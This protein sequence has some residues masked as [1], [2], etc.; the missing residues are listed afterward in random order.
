MRFYRSSSGKSKS[1]R[2][3]DVNAYNR[4]KLSGSSKIALGLPSV[5]STDALDIFYTQI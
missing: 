1:K 4:L 2:L 3:P 5:D